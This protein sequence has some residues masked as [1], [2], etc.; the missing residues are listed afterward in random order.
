MATYYK[1]RKSQIK[2]DKYLMEK[3]SESGYYTMTGLADSNAVYIGEYGPNESFTGQNIVD[4][5]FKFPT[6]S[7]IDKEGNYYSANKVFGRGPTSDIAVASGDTKFSV[8]VSR[9]GY[10]CR[11]EPNFPNGAP[12][13]VYGV[14]AVAGSF[15]EYVYST[16]ASAYPNGGVKDGYY[17][18]QRSTAESPTAPTGLTCPDPIVT[19]SAAVSWTAAQ[20]GTDYPV[21]SYEV[22]RSTDGGSSWTVVNAAVT[23]TSL[24]VE[25]P[26]GATVIRFRVRAKDSNGQ[27]GGYVTG[28]DVKVL[29]APTLT[30]PVMVMRGQ[31][32]AVS[33][34]A[35]EGADS[36]TL[37]RKA[38]TDAD[39]VQ[40]Y[41]GA[42]LTFT[43]TAGSWTSVQY[44]V[45][46]VVG[47]VL[48]KWSATGTVQVTAASALVISGKDG[49]LG[50]LTADVSYSISTDTG[51]AITAAV[52][53]NGIRQADFSPKN[54]ETY[55]VRVLDL[56]TGTG[57]IVVTASVTKSGAPL[58]VT[59][60][61]TYTKTAAEFPVAGSVAQ[62]ERDGKSVWPLTVAEAVRTAN[63]NLS[64]DLNLLKTSV[65]E[66]KALV[67]T[68]V[69]G[70]GVQTA[71]D[72]TFQK[73]ADN[74]KAIKVGEISTAK[75]TYHGRWGADPTN[76]TAP[77][78]LKLPIS[79][80]TV[81]FVYFSTYSGDER[82]QFKYAKI[83]NK[84]YNVSADYYSELDKN[85][86]YISGDLFYTPA[87]TSV[88]DMSGGNPF[89]C[90]LAF[91]GK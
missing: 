33:W 9:N 21:Q 30:V 12:L 49:D 61:W 51:S 73:I 3:V 34:S 54:G 90:I 72:A 74:I 26:A 2:Y 50:T 86:A 31:P 37:Q 16:N 69:T 7:T 29:P 17:Y 91:C 60:T 87:S 62:L 20:S 70:K 14:K 75:F 22:S 47:G 89:S 36:Y 46:A 56:P 15:V 35:V 8:F 39:W 44:R 65:S 24:T 83:G 43:E 84:I 79:N 6:R 59:R 41:S 82:W 27:W 64:I 58:T 85:S 40:V 42:A 52:E 19:D 57:R 55:L 1:W 18:D 76:R 81:F 5:K 68:A 45:Q 88:N 38:D 11:I 78:V 23:G 77:Y 66:G 71:V 53:V 63:G 32:A 67:A 28:A 80:P 10:S 4:G 25:I 13:Y 48:G